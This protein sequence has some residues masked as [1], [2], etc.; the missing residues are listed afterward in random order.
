MM[1]LSL[2]EQERSMIQE[3]LDRELRDLRFEIADTDQSGYKAKLRQREIEL[4]ALLDR[5]GGPLPDRA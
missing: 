4:R 3:I 1:E 2:T 5:V